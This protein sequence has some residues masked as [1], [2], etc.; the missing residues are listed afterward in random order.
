[1]SLYNRFTPLSVIYDN[2]ECRMYPMGDPK[3]QVTNWKKTPLFAQ[4]HSLA[5]AILNYY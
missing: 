1:M 5:V 4:M 3:L 2:P